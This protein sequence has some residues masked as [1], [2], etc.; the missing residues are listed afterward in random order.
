M[1]TATIQDYPSLLVRIEQLRSSTLAAEKE[2]KQSVTDLARTS[3]W[4]MFAEK[5]RSTIQKALR[6]NLQAQDPLAIPG[7]IIPDLLSSVAPLAWPILKKLILNKAS[8]FITDKILAK[9]KP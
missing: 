9:S 1:Q 6:D 8:H 5:A 3:S 2:L 4:S 7:K